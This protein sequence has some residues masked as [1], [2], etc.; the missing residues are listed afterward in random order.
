MPEE[1]EIEKLQDTVAKLEDISILF[2][3]A[4][5]EHVFSSEVEAK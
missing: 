2:E 3:D 4:E 1:K 5:V